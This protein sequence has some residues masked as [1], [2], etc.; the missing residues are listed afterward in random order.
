MYLYPY[1]VLYFLRMRRELYEIPIEEYSQNMRDFRLVLDYI[2][3][4]NYNNTRHV[5][6]SIPVD[7]Y[8]EIDHPPKIDI[9][10]LHKYRQ[11]HFMET[12]ILSDTIK[13][14][15]FRSF[16]IR[17]SLEGRRNISIISYFLFHTHGLAEIGNLNLLD[18]LKNLLENYDPSIKDVEILLYN[19]IFP[20]GRGSYLAKPYLNEIYDILIEYINSKSPGYI[21]IFEIPRYTRLILGDMFEKF[22]NDGGMI[23]LSI[24]IFNGLVDELLKNQFRDSFIIVP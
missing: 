10:F 6:S 11:K 19:I 3:L 23:K 14:N 17:I 12:K 21:I 24:N 9:P 15:P 16:W 7:I 18:I 2:A 8:E 1:Q 20:W 4:Y 5:D 22:F 13:Q